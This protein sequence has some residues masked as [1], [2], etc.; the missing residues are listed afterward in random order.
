M[1]YAATTPLDPRVFEAMRPYFTTIYGNPSSINT[2]GLDAKQALEDSRRIVSSIMNGTPDELI[3]TGSATEANNLALKGF[4]FR[5]GRNKTHIA[6][7]EIEHDCVLNTAK[8]LEERG[9][10]ITNLPV[11]RNGL[12]DPPLFLKGFVWVGLVIGRMNHGHWPN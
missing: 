5:E 8:W 9:F 2:F 7:S 12:L 4:A 6:I 3:F 10:K 1:D 11:D